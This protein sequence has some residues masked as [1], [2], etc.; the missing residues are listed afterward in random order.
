MSKVARKFSKFEFSDLLKTP[1]PAYMHFP[2]TYL[3]S[4]AIDYSL[5]TP[6]LTKAIETQE[7]IER[8]KNIVCFYAGGNHINVSQ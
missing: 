7:P 6:Y 8:L 2:R 3:E 5:A 1:A 4:A